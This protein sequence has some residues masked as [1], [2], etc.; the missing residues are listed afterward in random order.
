MNI[1]NWIRSEYVTIGNT[2]LPFVWRAEPSVKRVSRL[3]LWFPMYILSFYRVVFN[4]IIFKR[5][6]ENSHKRQIWKTMHC[7]WLLCTLQRKRA[8][9]VRQS[10]EK[11]VN[12]ILQNGNE[13]YVEKM[14]F[15]G[16]AKRSTKTETN[17]K[18]RYKKKSRYG[19][20]IGNGALPWKL[21]EKSQ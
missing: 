11:L 5:P 20:P 13:I 21:C 3:A 6:S 4:Q 7:C 10:H 9:V 16:L 14:T 12:R 1:Q 2:L 19:K 18:G 15:S 17:Q 8:D